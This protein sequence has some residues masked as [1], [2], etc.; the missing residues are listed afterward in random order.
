MQQDQLERYIPKCLVYALLWS[1]AGDGRLKVLSELGDFIR[2]VA[3]VP[4]PANMGLPIIDYE[5]RAPLRG[6]IGGL[7]GEIGLVGSSCI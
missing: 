7:F 3:T 6:V 1:F 2:S 4:L 5:V